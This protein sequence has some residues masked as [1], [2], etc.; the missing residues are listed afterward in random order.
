MTIFIYIQQTDIKVPMPIIT[1]KV[2]RD[3]L[4]I[5]NKNEAVLTA[6]D[7]ADSNEKS[8]SGLSSISKLA[9]R[10]LEDNCIKV[11]TI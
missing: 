5:P 10:G 3:I 7:V 2:R 9:K 4:K 11:S 8:L 6:K 1:P